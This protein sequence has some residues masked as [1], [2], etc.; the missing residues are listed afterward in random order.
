MHFLLKR[1]LSYIEIFISLKSVKLVAWSSLI[2]TKQTFGSWPIVLVGKKN[3]TQIHLR[4]FWQTKFV[5]FLDSMSFFYAVRFGNLVCFKYRSISVL[6]YIYA[7]KQVLGSC[8]WH[9][10]VA[11]FVKLAFLQPQVKSLHL[12][13]K[14]LLFPSSPNFI[15][16]RQHWPTTSFTFFYPFD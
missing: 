8:G 10:F 14:G 16:W 11:N 13:T 5:F 12:E 6:Q 9:F 15:W 3:F 4:F 7:S 2:K 1:K